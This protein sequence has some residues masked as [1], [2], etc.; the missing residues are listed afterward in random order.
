MKL[1]RALYQ[2]AYLWFAAFFVMMLAGF[3]LTYF[4]RL[5]DQDNYRMHTHGVSLVLW[6]LMLIAQAWLIRR[7]AYPMHRR[8]GRLSYLLVPVIVLTTVDLFQY[9]MGDVRDMPPRGYVFSA[10]VILA[11]LL[12]ILYYGLAIRYRKKSAL[13]ARCMVCTIFPLFTPITDRIIAIHFRGWIPHLPSVDGPV[14]QSAGLGLAA[15]LLAG[16][17]V[18]DWR[19]HGR[20]GVFALALVLQLGYFYAVMNFHAF[21]WWR[22]FSDW[23]IGL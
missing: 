6:C 13:H 21:G 2:S 3:W 20:W 16:L 5:A 4:T 22:A 8:I 14:L 10:S 17:T 12:F 9:T 19:A 23:F 11:L 18:W 1:D 7:K 15:A